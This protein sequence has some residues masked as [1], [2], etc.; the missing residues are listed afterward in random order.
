[1]CWP[2][3]GQDIHHRVLDNIVFDLFNKVKS[4]DEVFPKLLMMVVF[5]V[6][7]FGKVLVRFVRRLYGS[8][9]NE[10]RPAIAENFKRFQD[11]LG[12]SDAEL[13]R[14]TGLNPSY[15]TAL[16]GGRIADPGVGTLGKIAEAMG[17][18]INDL[19]GEGEGK[20]VFPAPT[21]YLAQMYSL[22]SEM[23]KLIIKLLE[24]SA[25][26][27]GGEKVSEPIKRRG[28][29]AI[30]YGMLERSINRSTMESSPFGLSEEEQRHLEALREM[31]PEQKEAVFSLVRQLTS[32]K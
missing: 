30:A 5:G 32:K 4:F 9:M 24:V 25:Q 15:F 26:E 13:A 7:V 2:V 14:R 1:L 17:V 22:P 19:I 10:P 12:V 31:P 28:I 20:I 8:N 11:A 6:M 27:M 3:C 16:G 18:S 21:I 29:G 23:V